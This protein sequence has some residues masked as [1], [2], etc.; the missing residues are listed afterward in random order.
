M[1]NLNRSTSDIITLATEST[2]S[3]S[4]LHLRKLIN[5]NVNPL[6]FE[7]LGF[8]LI[9]LCDVDKLYVKVKFAYI[10]QPQLKVLVFG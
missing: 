6:L 9:K 4:S 3:T 5:H 8:P 1:E 10:E 2:S 7:S